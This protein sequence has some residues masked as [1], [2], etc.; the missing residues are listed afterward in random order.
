MKKILIGVVLVFL[1]VPSYSSEWNISFDKDEM[2]GDKSAY[3]SSDFVYPTERMN[4]PYRNTKAWLGMGCNGVSEWIYV[5]FN[6]A[7]NLT[8][9][10]IERG[11]YNSID[12]RIKFDDDKVEYTTFIQDW[13][14]KFLSFTN[15]E[16][17]I[18]NIAKSNT[19]L[20]ELKWYGNGKTYFRFPLK[21]SSNAIRKIRN[22]C[23]SIK[24]VEKKVEKKVDWKVNKIEEQKKQ[25]C[26]SSGSTWRYGE[27]GDIV[28]GNYKN[29]SKSSLI[30]EDLKKQD[31]INGGSTWRYGENGD[32]VCGNY[33]NISKSSL[34]EEDLKKQSCI[35]RGLTWRYGYYGDIVCGNR[36]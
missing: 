4:F 34:T 36:Q 18:S 19:L 29:I 2:T 14:S 31:C 35:N 20:L 23:N 5:G 6:P 12:T 28:C 15:D 11:G 27:N 24:K 25:D 3:L 16:Y 10:E 7:P 33:K 13:G 17:I 21:G 30:E 22:F 1:V 9:I 32:I 26:I 8:D